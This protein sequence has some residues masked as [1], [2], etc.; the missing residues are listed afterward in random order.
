MVTAVIL[1]LSSE[2]SEAKTF[3]NDGYFKMIKI[4]ADDPETYTLDWVK[5]TDTITLNG[6]E[7]DIGDHSQYTNDLGV[8]LAFTESTVSRYVSGV[9]LQSWS[10]QWGGSHGFSGDEIII[11]FNGGTQTLTAK[12]AGQ[13]DSV[14]TVTYE[15]AYIAANSGDY[16]MKKSNDASYV[17]SDSEVMAM[18]ITSINNSGSPLLSVIKMTGDASSVQFEAIVGATT[19][20]FDDIEIDSSEI[21]GYVDLYGLKKVTATATYDGE[22]TAITYS[23]FVVPHNVES[24]P[25]NPAAY[26]SLVMVIPLMSFVVLVVAAAAMIYLKKD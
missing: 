3:T 8:S 11:E 19:A 16:A 7:I 4:S 2:Y 1:P 24:D 13:S 14:K 12:T 9:R 15:Y 23:Y 6:V 26:K 20:T 18:G 10:T 5:S 21:N 22:D 25:D 17:N